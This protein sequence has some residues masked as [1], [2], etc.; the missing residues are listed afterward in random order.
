MELNEIEYPDTPANNFL[1]TLQNLITQKGFECF[2]W[3]AFTNK[4]HNYLK[5]STYFGSN[6]K[7]IFNESFIELKNDFNFNKSINITNEKDYGVDIIIE[8]ITY[9]DTTAKKDDETKE[10]TDNQIEISRDELISICEDSIVGFHNWM[11]RDSYSSQVLVADI[12]A[13]LNTGA[14][15]IVTNENDHTLW[16][17]FQN[18]TLENIKDMDLYYLAHDSLDE[19]KEEYPDDEMFDGHGLNI[20]HYNKTQTDIDITFL[21]GYLPTRK[22]LQENEGEDWY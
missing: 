12:Y 4:E 3:F 2:K 1:F 20:N 15:Y 18:V 7:D 16:I 5:I 9:S 13:L 17:T 10:E 6:S 21:H 22:R 19:Y 14:D 8:N 11:N